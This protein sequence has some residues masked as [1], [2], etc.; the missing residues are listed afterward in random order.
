M[1][2]SHGIPACTDMA[3]KSRHTLFCKGT[4]CFRLQGFWL[5]LACLLGVF[6]RNVVELYQTTRRRIPED[7]AV[8][9]VTAVST[10]NPVGIAAFSLEYTERPPVLLATFT[11]AFLFCSR[12]RRTIYLISYPYL[13]VCSALGGLLRLR[14]FFV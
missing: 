3:L 2:W 4:C 12:S 7:F 11:G 13:M 8:F 5:L 9:I 6:L 10:S 14:L 1:F